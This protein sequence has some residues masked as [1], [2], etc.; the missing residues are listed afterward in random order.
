M[1]TIL[2]LL[3]S[4]AGLGVINTPNDGAIFICIFLLEIV[5]MVITNIIADRLT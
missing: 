4:P 3:L 1:I 5:E 2:F